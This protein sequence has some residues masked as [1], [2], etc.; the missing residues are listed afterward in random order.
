MDR[1]SA[2]NAF[3]ASVLIIGVSLGVILFRRVRGEQLTCRG[4][5]SGPNPCLGGYICSTDRDIIERTISAE[6]EM[7]KVAELLTLSLI[8]LQSGAL[9]SAQTCEYAGQTFSVGATICECPNLRIVRSATSPGRGEITSR[10]LACSKDQ[11]WVNTNSLCLVAYTSADHAE[12]A[13]RKFQVSYCPRLPVNHAELLK[14][15]SEEPK[16][17]SAWRR[18]AKYL[19]PSRPFAAGLPTYRNRAR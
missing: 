7:H 8:L 9:A 15:I 6:A 5:T 14:A 10:R 2:L 12:D 1:G 4:A 13:F 17:F 19:S 18:G 11:T 16:S 3:G